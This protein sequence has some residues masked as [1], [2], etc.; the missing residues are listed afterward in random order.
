VPDAPPRP[1]LL[2]RLEAL[3]AEIDDAVR[4]LV[5]LHGARLRC[6]LGCTRCCVDDLTIFEV[7]ADRI[8]A[9]AASVLDEAPRPA[10]ACAFL[11]DDGACR[12]YAHRPYVCRTQG[13]PL[14]WFDSDERGATLELRDICALNEP[15]E[16]AL[17]ALPESCCWLLGPHEARLHELARGWDGG[18]RVA[19]RDLFA[20]R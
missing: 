12:I 19:L 1:I 2:A 16:P 7:E 11:G 20:R 6:R 9:R 4:P 10:G 15:G 8:R 14:R 5:A 13:L 3:H 17:E 18:E